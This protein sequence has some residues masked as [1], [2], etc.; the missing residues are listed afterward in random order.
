[1]SKFSDFGLL[2][3]LLETLKTKNIFK[4]T[5]IQNNA[6]P[7]IMSGQSVVGVSETGSGKT[8]AYALPLLHLL[9]TLE[10]EGKPVTEVAKPRAIVM[11]PTRDLGEQV[12]KVFKTL[13]SRFLPIS[14]NCLLCWRISREILREKSGESTSP[15]TNLRYS[16]RRSWQLSMIKTCLE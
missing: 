13:F 9:K 1:M 10:N 6:I 8:L 5:E 3:S 4:P 14:F 2:P 15:R 12:S 7:M 16:G 11:L